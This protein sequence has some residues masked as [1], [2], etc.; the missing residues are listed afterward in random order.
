MV[1]NLITKQAK[2]INRRLARCPNSLTERK[3]NYSYNKY[4]YFVLDTMLN[5]YY[6]N[7]YLCIL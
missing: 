7:T 3:A 6:I 1:N 2:D 4:T 5:I